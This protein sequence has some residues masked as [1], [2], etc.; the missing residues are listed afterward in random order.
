MN[1]AWYARACL[2]RESWDV[3]YFTRLGEDPYS[4][5]MLSFFEQNAIDTSLIGQH[6]SRR[7]GL[8]MIEITNGERS[9]TYWRD[10][11]AAKTL[12]DD[13]AALSKV[14]AA[15]D[16]I[17]FSGITMAI[18]PEAGRANLLEEL[19]TARAAGKTIVFDPNL[20]PRLWTSA[21]EMRDVTMRAAGV[22]DIL[23]PSFDDEATTFGDAD[24]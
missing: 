9:F 16:T 1:T 8:Y 24:L 23:L 21:E 18:L 19:R 2:P 12:A 15:A 7:P 13:R 22:S 11:S 3:S 10:Q 14:F 20:R 4:Q 6:P 17:Y 5:K